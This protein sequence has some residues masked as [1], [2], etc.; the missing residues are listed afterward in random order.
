MKLVIF[1]LTISSS[2][3]NGH[4]TLWRALCRGLHARGHEI[5]FFERDVPYYARHRDQHE[6][7]GCT[8]RLYSQWEDVVTEARRSLRDADVGMVTSYCP[9]GRVAAAAVLD[10]T[11]ALKVYYD[12][13]TPVTLARLRDG[14]RVDYLPATDSAPSISSS[15]TPAATR[16]GSCA[17]HLAHG[18][19]RRSM[20]ASIRMSTGRSMPTRGSHVTSRISARTRPI[21]RTRSTGCSSSRRF[22]VRPGGSHWPG[23]MYPPDFRW[24]PNMFYLSHLPPGDHPSFYC[25]S[26]L[27]LNITRGPMA[28]MGFCPSGRLFEAAACGT[29]MLSDWWEGLD[30]FFTPGRGDSR[31][32]NDTPDAVAALDLSDAERRAVGR[33]ARERALDCHTAAI[34]AGELE[35]LIGAAVEHQRFHGVTMW[36]IV[37]AAG[38]GS[39]MQPLAFSKELLPVGSR[40]DGNRE[41]PR[42]VSEYLVERLVLGG[43][44]KICFVISPGKSDILEYYGGG[45]SPR[46]SSTACSRTRPGCATPSSARFRSSTTTSR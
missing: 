44:D 7:Q 46:A 16:S 6:P 20:A 19:S 33:R 39:R 31:S 22:G 45:V 18:R 21:A 2:W 24:T 14:Q 9:D 32:P 3:G 27:T 11:A 38:Q 5:V 23:R 30:A 34:R 35:Q 37:P 43:A 10:S 15:A 40:R 26:S 8:L 12:L 4:A 13:D 41:R 36:G 42:A 17:R 29:A 1:G 25:S 28:E